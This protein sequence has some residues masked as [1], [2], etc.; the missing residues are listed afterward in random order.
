MVLGRDRGIYALFHGESLRN[1]VSRK[2]WTVNVR[3]G[4]PWFSPLFRIVWCKLFPG[5]Y[6]EDFG[7]RAGT[8]VPFQVLYTGPSMHAVCASVGDVCHEIL[9]GYYFV[10][11]NLERNLVFWDFRALVDSIISER[12]EKPMHKDDE[13]VSHLAATHML[14]Y[15]LVGVGAQVSKYVCGTARPDFERI[16][17]WLCCHLWCREPQVAKQYIDVAVQGLPYV[18]VPVVPCGIMLEL[19]MSA[20]L[21][22]TFAA[23]SYPR[24]LSYLMCCVQR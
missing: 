19:L 21:C 5:I 9:H 23:P 11:V 20:D 10:G 12:S 2:G 4:P 1:S 16:L 18:C 8:R 13:N 15:G 14:V 17:P 24:Q 3:R 7:F 6:G 22:H